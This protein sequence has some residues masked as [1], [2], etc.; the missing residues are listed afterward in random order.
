MGE[1]EV[2]DLQSAMQEPLENVLAR[3]PYKIS[4]IRGESYKGKKGVWWITTNEGV[5]ILKKVSNSEQT[6]QFIL[7]AVRHLTANGIDLPGVNLTKDGKEYVCLE[8]VCYVLTEA[9][10]GKNPNYGSAEELA[11]IARSLGRFHRASKGFHPSPVTKPKYHLGLWIE[12]YTEQL[13]DIKSYYESECLKKTRD[14]IGNAVVNSFPGFYER[15]QKAIEGLRGHEY[16]D[17]TQEAEKAGCL[18][19]QDYAAGNL[20]LTPKG[21]LFVLDTDS[22]TVDI[23]ARDIRK[24]LNKVMKKMGKWDMETTRRILK[25]YQSENPLTASQW[26]V[27]RLDLLFPHLFLGAVNKFIYKRDQDWSNEKYLERINEMTEFEKSAMP[28]LK[29]FKSVIPV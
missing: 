18:C 8:E 4:D 11:L 12:D 23:A 27:V 10:D 3:Y 19:H 29:D 2:S 6:L 7:D 25:Q 5:K 13:T 22:I 9:I 20:I 15:A 26:E 14:A 1:K 17:W 28:V 21:R 24:L 16:A